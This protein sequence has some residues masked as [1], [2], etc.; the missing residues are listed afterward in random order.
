MRSCCRFIIGADAD[1]CMQFLSSV[2][3]VLRYMEEQ[4]AT[5]ST[6]N[7]RDE[8]IIN[9]MSGDGGSQVDVVLYLIDQGMYST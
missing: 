8:D 3:P 6:L 7:M 2:R 4:L 1:A 5:S 9:M